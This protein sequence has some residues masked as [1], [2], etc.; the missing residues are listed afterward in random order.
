MHIDSIYCIDGLSLCGFQVLPEVS[1]PVT[2]FASGAF[3]E[4]RISS[5][6]ICG[7]FCIAACSIVYVAIFVGFLD[8]GDG[9]HTHSLSVF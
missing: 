1:F 4:Q 7:Y 5:V 6:I 3:N 9:L 2:A 8:V